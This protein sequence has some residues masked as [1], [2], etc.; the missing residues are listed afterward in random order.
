MAELKPI[1]ISSVDSYSRNNGLP[2]FKDTVNNT[3]FLGLNL[4][5]TDILSNQSDRQYYVEVRFAFRP[6]KI[7]YRFYKN[8]L[9]GWYICQRNDIIDPFDPDEGLFPGRLITI[10]AKDQIVKQVV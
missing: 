2:I 9:L 8:P 3:T 5:S 6:D 4:K 7:S 10:P 1:G